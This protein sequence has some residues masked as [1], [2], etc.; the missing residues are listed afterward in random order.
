V[1]I[2]QKIAEILEEKSCGKMELP[3]CSLLCFVCGGVMEAYMLRTGLTK[4][5][6]EGQWRGE[7]G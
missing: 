6:L 5:F 7:D 1:Q 4:S 2:V 3:S